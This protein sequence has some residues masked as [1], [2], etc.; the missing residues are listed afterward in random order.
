MNTINLVSVFKDFV[1][2]EGLEDQKILLLI[3]GGVDSMVLLDVASRSHKAQNL[4]VMHFDHQTRPET[5]VERQMIENRCKTLNIDFCGKLIDECAKNVESSWRSQ[6]HKLST[7]FAQK[8]SA[9]RIL[10]AHHATDLVETMLFR[11]TKGCGVAGLSP[12]ETSTKPFWQV[13]KS[14][15]ITYAE[16]NQI[17][18]IEDP[19]NA[20]NDHD[21]NRIRN[22]VL[23]ALRKIT[24]N[25]EKVFVNEAHT[26]GLTQDYLQQNVDAFLK[27]KLTPCG[28]G[29][30]G[31]L[32]LSEL[33]SLH[34]IIQTEFLRSICPKTPSAAEM[35]DFL[36]WI[37]N[38]PEGGSQK[39]LGGQ[40]FQIEKQTLIWE[41]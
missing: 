14:Q 13:P 27:E 28:G 33:L 36:R 23:P 9:I 20:E 19:T 15:I 32:N 41:T 25:L 39:E 22:E 24:P 17:Q 6:R 11:M 8:I 18:W 3:S 21:R 29:T 40:E 31:G 34:P 16:E 2:A 30:G 12:F 10:T 38:N 37:E 4:S 35:K 26:F 5:L 1:S 7:E